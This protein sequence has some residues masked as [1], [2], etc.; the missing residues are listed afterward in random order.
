MHDLPGKIRRIYVKMIYTK[1]RKWTSCGGR[2]GG[3]SKRPQPLRGLDRVGKALFLGWV[4][5]REIHSLRLMC[6]L[7]TF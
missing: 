3:R 4:V 5:K 6:N 2:E 7:Y 1:F